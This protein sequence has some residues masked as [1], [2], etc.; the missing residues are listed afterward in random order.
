MGTYGE[1]HNM[2]KMVILI[3]TFHIQILMGVNSLLFKFSLKVSLFSILFCV[4]FFLKYRSLFMELPFFPP[5]L[6]KLLCCI[7]FK[8]LPCS[9]LS[10]S[11][12]DS[13]EDRILQG[14]SKSFRIRQILNISNV[15][16][17]MWKLDLICRVL[18]S[19]ENEG[20]A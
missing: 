4:A 18:S 12:N 17:K 14:E 15:T 1:K 6:G 11:S 9:P 2:E 3:I 20:K 19:S 7:S 8:K 16:H 10:H 13:P 5:L